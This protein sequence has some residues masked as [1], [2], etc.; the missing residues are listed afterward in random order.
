MGSAMTK[1]GLGFSRYTLEWGTGT[2]PA[3]YSTGGITLMNSGLQPVGSGK[4][5]T[6]D[7][8]SLLSGQVYTLR[9]IATASSGITSQYSIKVTLDK[10]LV[11]GWPKLISRGTRCTICEATPTVDDLDNDGV[12]EVVITS[13]DNKLY[14]FRK[15]GTDFPGFPVSVN[16]GEF[17]SWPANVADLDNDG[18]QE[19][20]TASVT[21]SGTSKV[22]IIRSD[23]TYYPGWPQ[24]VHVIGQ[25]SGDG[26]PTIADLNGDG[27]K[28]MV[29]IDPYNKKMH[30]YNLDGTELAGFPKTLPFSDLEYPGAPSIS[31]LDN[32]G[33]PEIAYGLKNKFY[34][35]DHQGNVIPGW[36]F[37]APAYNGNTI[38]FDSSAASGDIDGDGNLEIVAIGH[39]GGATSPIYAWKKDGNVLSG[40]PMAGGTLSYGHS[41][42]NSPSLIDV[43][44]DGKDEAVVGLY[45]LSIFDLEGKKSLGTGIG[46]KIAPAISDVDGNGIFEFAGIRDNKVQIGKVDGSLFWERIFS[47]NA[48]FVSP[49]VFSDLDNNGRVEFSVLQARFAGESGDLLAYLWE[50]PDMSIQSSKSWPMFLHDPMRSG[51]MA[52]LS[53]PSDIISP[54]TSITDPANAATIYGSIEVTAE[55]SD[56]SGVKKVE[57]YRNNVLIGTDTSN[58]FI[59]NWDTVQEQN[60]IH[61]LQSRAYDIVNNVGVS[62]MITVTVNNKVDPGDTIA[63][64]VMITY[65]QNN[66]YVPKKST[67]TITANAS[68]NIGVTKAEFTINGNLVCTDTTLNYSCNWKVPPR[69]GIRYAILMK[70]YDAK[71]N[72]GYSSASVISK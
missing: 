36:P 25:Q 34:L 6:W 58:P 51:H 46:A 14:V 19:I 33:F 62:Q 10:D 21:S 49:S 63:P 31:D 18:K 2:S 32:D 30:A 71:G 29:V 38:Y 5:A 28:D 22:Y 7:T 40:W 37:M 11:K 9:L 16:P 42:M 3:T 1:N 68:D 48:H 24:P 27:R 39:N 57:L 64:V 60:G 13:P 54:A 35:F 20:V 45:S 15:D 44:N 59:F 17:F 26:T 72:I 70:A 67:V 8:S 43:D 47:T 4:L 56:N 61:T 65:P 50:L 23:G 69:S 12:S 52:V 66:N 53:V 41:P 55:A